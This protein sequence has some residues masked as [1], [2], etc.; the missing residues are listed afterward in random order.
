[1]PRSRRAL[2]VTERLVH[3]IPAIS[4]VIPRIVLIDFNFSKR[5]AEV[6]SW[7]MV[8]IAGLG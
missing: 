8:V 2:N 3:F 5:I 1:M 4:S 6:D 7:H